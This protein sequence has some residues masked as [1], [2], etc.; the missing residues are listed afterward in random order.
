MDGQWMAD[1][2]SEETMYGAE[3]SSNRSSTNNSNNNTNA[4]TETKI[5]VGSGESKFKIHQN[6]HTSS[7]TVSD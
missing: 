4:G 6:N 5:Y 1:A 2:T 7:F 3:V